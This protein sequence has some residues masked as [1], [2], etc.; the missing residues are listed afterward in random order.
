MMKKFI[1]SIALLLAALSV[2]VSCSMF[3]LDN[4]DGP[5]A[6]VTG[7]LLDMETGEL[8]SLEAAQSQ[9]FSWTTWSYVTTTD[10]GAIVVYEQGYVPP[11]WAGNPEDYTG[12]DS[13]QAWLVRFDGQFT[14]NMVFAGTY[15]YSLQKLL[16]CYDPEEGKDTFVL[17][18]GKNK[19]DIGVLPFC[20]VKDPKISYDAASKK[21][22]AQ[23]Y[24]ELGDPSRA[25]KISNVIF[26]A[27]TQLFVG[28]NNLNLAK[29]HKPAKAQDVKPGELITLEIDTTAPENA[30]LFKY[31]TQDRY[32][33]IGAM[34]EGNGYNSEKNKY[35]NF[36]PIFKVS[37]DFST[38]EEVKWDDMVW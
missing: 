31:S 33:R 28:G 35:Y 1:I 12:K 19:V 15:K 38:I 5:N 7:R 3:K 2:T 29:D 21:M 4:F 37:A 13:G 11:T 26:S 32:F 14:N 9:T 20:R 8:V 22:I 10:Y 36:S 34:A 30:D 23:F 6:Q 25:N 27:N 16:P 24:V 18:E 17:K